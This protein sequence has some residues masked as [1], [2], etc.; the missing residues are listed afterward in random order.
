MQLTIEAVYELI[1]GL[2]ESGS[3]EIADLAQESAT[4]ASLALIKASESLKEANESLLQITEQA[5][6]TEERLNNE[7]F[8]ILQNESTGVPK[9]GDTFEGFKVQSNNALLMYAMKKIEL[10]K[11][12]LENLRLEGDKKLEEFVENVIKEEERKT[13]SQLSAQEENLKRDFEVLLLKKVEHFELQ[14]TVM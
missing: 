4:K 14:Q 6:L 1:N 3:S 10:L 13:N 5:T 8:S 7:V 2:R 12:D 9:N 11:S